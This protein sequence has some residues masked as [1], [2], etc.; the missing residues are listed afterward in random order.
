MVTFRADER[1]QINLQKTFN[2]FFGIKDI[3]RFSIQGYLIACVLEDTY[4]YNIGT[5]K[6]VPR[7]K[8]NQVKTVAWEVAEV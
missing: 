4:I 3:K 8:N 2:L 6:F 7:I 5:I 1:F